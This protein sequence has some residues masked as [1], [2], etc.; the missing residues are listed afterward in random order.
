ME[1]AALRR[2]R[3][4]TQHEVAERLGVDQSTVSRMENGQNV[5][6]Q[7]L[8][9]YLAVVGAR[10]ARIVATFDQGEIELNVIPGTDLAKGA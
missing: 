3:D 5:H 2:Y 4:L 7:A 9:R 1:L 6:V 10:S 8:L